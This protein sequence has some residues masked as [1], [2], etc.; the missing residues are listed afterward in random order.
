VEQVALF[1]RE[2][3]HEPIDQS[4]EFLEVAVS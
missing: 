3:E 1:H 2:H 4:Q